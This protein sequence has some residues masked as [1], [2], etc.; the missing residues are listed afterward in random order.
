MA[1]LNTTETTEPT[2]VRLRR[3]RRPGHAA[4][5]GRSATSTCSARSTST[6]GR[7]ELVVLLGRSGCGKS[8]LLRSLAH[9]D[10]SPAS[11]V[12]VTGRTAVAFQEPRLL[13]WRRVRENVE[14]AL[15]NTPERRDR[16]RARR[17]DARARS[18]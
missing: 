8:T 12:Q 9:L 11:E 18:A 2:D 10:P 1:R 14:L 17:G 16:E 15:L 6:S 13:P 7:G 5:T 3:V 4:T